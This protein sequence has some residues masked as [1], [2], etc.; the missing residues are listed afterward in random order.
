MLETTPG[1]TP[2]RAVYGFAW[3]LF[4]KTLFVLYL[5]W[6]LV[7]EYIQQNVLGLTYLPDKYFAMV[8]PVWVL[9]ALTFFAFLIYPPWNMAMQD[10]INDVHTIRD[11]KTIRRCQYVYASTGKRCAQ[12]V[13]AIPANESND[14]N[15]WTFEQ[16]CSEHMGSDAESLAAEND[17]LNSFCDCIDKAHCLL[18]KRPNH[19]NVLRKRET[20]PSI[21][22][23]D[24]VDV[25]EQ[26]FLDD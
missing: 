5:F 23:L 13:D 17:Q 9:T 26:L 22:D 3:F 16:Y 7:P 14:F 2:N 11:S 18:T 20:V 24:I 8:L 12:K 19:L 1:P 15:I 4:S 6:A 25:S 10:D 21:L